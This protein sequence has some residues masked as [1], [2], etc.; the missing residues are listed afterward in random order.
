MCFL[1]IKFH[2]SFSYALLLTINIIFSAQSQSLFEK[3]YGTFADE[4]AAG[5][6]KLADGGFIVAGHFDTGNGLFDLCA[7]RINNSGDIVWSKRYGGSGDDG[8]RGI[9]Q[10]TDGNFVLMGYNGSTGFGGYDVL[11]IKIDPIGNQLWSAI[12]GDGYLQEGF[13]ITATNDGGVVITGYTKIYDISDVYTIKLDQ[14]GSLV[15]TNIIG[16]TFKQWGSSIIQTKDGGYLITGITDVGADW[17]PNFNTLILK[18]SSAGNLV[19]IKHFGGPLTEEGRSIVELEDS[20]FVVVG[21]TN[22]FGGDY[23]SLVARFSND[24]EL[25]WMKIIGGSNDDI[26]NSVHFAADGKL[27]IGGQTNTY[28]YGSQ[29][30]LMKLDF[31]GNFL[32]Q[33]NYGQAGQEIGSKV[34]NLGD[35]AYAFV[36]ISSSQPIYYD[37]NYYVLVTD[38]SGES[39]CTNQSITPSIRTASLNIIPHEFISGTGGS[40]IN[41]LQPSSN[42]TLDALV[43][44][45]FLPVELESFNHSIEK[46]KATLTWSTATEIN[47]K[48][49]EIYRNDEIVKFVE[50]QGTTTEKHK[51]SYIDVVNTPGTYFYSLRQVDF[52]GTQTEL[53]SFEV[54]IE[55]PQAYALNQN[56]PN[57]FNP[58]TTISFTIPKDGNIQLKLYD[59]LGNE[60]IS[61]IDG[62]LPAGYH[63]ISLNGSELTNGVYFYKLQAENFID[64]KKLILLK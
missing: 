7:F 55:S 27:I 23:E 47:N 17:D 60:V 57:P 28:Q 49:F 1:P 33:K 16:F 51:Y 59:V 5:I 31:A 19:W 38:T 24:C 18:L 4:R 48:G 62:N 2:F 63:T 45:D 44:C 14:N 30:F 37:N 25:L 6:V 34:I 9:V 15:W 42:L 40:I 3:K 43:F 13:A 21:K 53:G 39:F 35:S 20:T 64:I 11:V 26:P 10:T 58:S 61:L 50:G 54:E 8:C 41:S 52:D 22:S 32:W 29:S 46:N 56:F 36:G 12:V